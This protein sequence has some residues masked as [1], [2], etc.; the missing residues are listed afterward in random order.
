MHYRKPLLRRAIFSAIATATLSFLSFSAAAE[1]WSAA[2]G[3]LPG[4]PRIIGSHGA[5]CIIG[6][7]QLPAEGEGYQTVDMERRRHYGHPTL[8]EYVQDL[9]R[10]VSAAGFGPI[11]VGDMAQREAGRCPSDM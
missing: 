6:A 5:A 10:R 3:P 11:L 2:S 7:Q 8:L 9:G 4:E 1:D